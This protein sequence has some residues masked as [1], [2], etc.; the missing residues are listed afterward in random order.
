MAK[1]KR[2]SKQKDSAARSTDIAGQ[3][4]HVFLAGLG[5]LSNTRKAG[6]KAFDTLV[7][8]G[9]SFRKNATDKTETLIDDVQEAI[10][11]MAGDAQSKATGLLDQMRETPQIDKLQGAFDARI[12]AAL[13]RL[14]VASKHD[15]QKLNAKLDKVLKAAKPAPA[16]KAAKKKAAKKKAAKAR[17]APA[18]PAVRKVAAKKAATKKAS[19]KKASSKKASSKK[20][21]SKKVA[22]KPAVKKVTVKS[23]SIEKASTEKVA[24]ESV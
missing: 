21:S 9:E 20:A 13:S 17:K 1:Q 23:T 14:G 8:Q 4:E 11:D 18:K 7:K 12:E 24:P 10:R 6:G 16:K 22:A 15:I 2:Q 19:T 3:L 5:A